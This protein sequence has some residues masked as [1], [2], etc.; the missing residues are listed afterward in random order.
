MRILENAK[1]WMRLTTIIV[2]ALFG[3]GFIVWE[4]IESTD[5]VLISE[6]MLKT[7]HVVE[8]AHS[9]LGRFQA[10]EAKGQ[11]TR[12]QAQAEALATLKALRYEGKEYFWVHD[13]TAPV[14]R[15]V[16]HATV[17]ALDGKLLDDA[18]FNNAKS[19]QQGVDGE[20][21]A[22]EKKN[23]FVA[24][25]E[26]IAKDGQGLVLYDWPKPKQGGGVTE[27]LYTKLSFVKRFDAWGWVVG[28]GI[29]ID[30]AEDVFWEHSLHSLILST[31]L[32]VILLVVG[33]TIARSITRQFGGEPADAIRVATHVAGG[34]LTEAV[35]VRPGD[36]HSVIHAL[37]SMQGSLATLVAKLRASAN[38]INAE[39][40]GLNTMAQD[41]RG[42]TAAQVEATS[43]TAA[44][45]QQTSA[46]IST[47]SD[48]ARQTEEE[49]AR[50]AELVRQGSQL[51][52]Q[53]TE[54]LQRIAGT[55][56][57]ASTKVATLKQRSE[58]INKISSVIKEIA[59]Q[60]NLLALNAAIEAARAGE[61]GRGFAVVADEVR[62]LAERTTAAT[63]EIES[64]I[65][66]IQ[67]ETY[68]AVQ[69][70]EEIVPKMEESSRH[71][72]EA[73][74][75]LTQ[76]GA[77]T[78]TTMQ[79]AREVSS[80]MLELNQAGQSIAGNVEKISQ[81]TQHTQEDANN[82]SRTAASMNQ[83]AAD[84]EKLVS[85]FRI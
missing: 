15:M 37:A 52:E 78:Q 72:Q 29:Y 69:S 60:T 1:V 12:E 36:T 63:T 66:A 64:V 45:V 34:D 84:L 46:A 13:L 5:E 51:V 59:G 26:A 20:P 3:L 2:V 49:S 40:G 4:A 56:A 44:A 48:N 70:I 10:L 28:S 21:R 39:A 54:E 76:I 6:R 67:S 71:S 32:T 14:P 22:V 53:T 31:V 8:V 25:N 30:D 73:A 41:L 82:A 75:A 11:L 77:S 7:K 18:K 65:A 62:K 23:L 83:L 42:A 50:N 43:A 19:I 35:S 57:A 16:M 74:A 80:A 68:I 55:V 79:R 85:G 9:V 38:S 81:M 33:I 61:Q 17:P 24:F 47:V 58:E 27:Q